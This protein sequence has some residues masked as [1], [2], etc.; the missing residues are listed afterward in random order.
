MSKLARK[1]WVMKKTDFEG[2]IRLQDSFTRTILPLGILL[3]KNANV[4]AVQEINLQWHVNT[5]FNM[6]AVYLVYRTVETDL[7]PKIQEIA[8]LNIK[9]SVKKSVKMSI[10]FAIYKYTGYPANQ[11]IT[12][13]T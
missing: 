11:N 1:P 7:T 6:C 8:R 13:R 2:S 5:L 10:S 4:K 9:L 3:Q 12:A